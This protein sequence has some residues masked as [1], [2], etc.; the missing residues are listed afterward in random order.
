MMVGV[1]SVLPKLAQN[2]G[3][4]A[5]S[6]SGAGGA[7]SLGLCAELWKVLESYGLRRLP[8]NFFHRQKSSS[9]HSLSYF[10]HRNCHF[11]CSIR[12]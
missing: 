2:F 7:M 8:A 10:D 11:G 5:A 4:V 3:V 12:I 6:G 1:C 9:P